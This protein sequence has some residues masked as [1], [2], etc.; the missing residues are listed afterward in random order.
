MGSI[1]LLI[2]GDICLSELLVLFFP[3]GSDETDDVHKRIFVQNAR[4]Q[5]TEAALTEMR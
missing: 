3:F 2:L 4:E 5:P 1:S